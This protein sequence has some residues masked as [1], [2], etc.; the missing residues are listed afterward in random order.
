MFKQVKIISMI[1]LYLQMNRCV[2]SYIHLGKLLFLF[3]SH[4]TWLAQ[5]YGRVCVGVCVREYAGV[6]ESV[7]V[8]AFPGNM[9]I[10][11]N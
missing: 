7:Y 8:Y 3:K 4:F 1:A 9:N 2:F 10:Y 6:R 11:S 5:I